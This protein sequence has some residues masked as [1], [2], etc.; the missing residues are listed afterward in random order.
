MLRF[1][2]IFCLLPQSEGVL[3]TARA[4]DLCLWDS[5]TVHCNSPG[6]AAE[7]K[8]SLGS[9]QTLSSSSSSSSSALP[10]KAH[11]Q[12]FAAPG[13]LKM[14]SLPGLA[15]SMTKRSA[16]LVIESQSDGIVRVVTQH[17]DEHKE[18]MESESLR[19]HFAV[20]KYGGMVHVRNCQNSEVTFE[21][22]FSKILIEGCSNCCFT[23][24]GPKRCLP[25]LHK[26]NT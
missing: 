1:V 16:R 22:T 17:L 19:T 3:V 5:R 4:G 18:T 8:S 13:R 2:L 23:V 26:R 9:K 20:G 15:E 10:P 7:T 11:V 25:S 24:R 12:R 21:G 14:P 6:I